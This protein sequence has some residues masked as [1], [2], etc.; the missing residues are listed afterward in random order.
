MCAGKA[1]FHI[2]FWVLSNLYTLLYSIMRSAYSLDAL[3]RLT[4]F[5]IFLFSREIQ[6]LFLNL[7]KYKKY[8]TSYTSFL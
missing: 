4:Y 6:N 7:V 2:Y 3:Q 8:S 5:T 1:Q